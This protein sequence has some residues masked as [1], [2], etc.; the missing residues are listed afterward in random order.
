M[1]EFKTEC[2][3]LRIMKLTR[4]A[5]EV[6]QGNQTG[7]GYDDGDPNDPWFARD[8]NFGNTDETVR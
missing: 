2:D 4:N 8:N 6:V 7:T 3:E 5:T 1:E